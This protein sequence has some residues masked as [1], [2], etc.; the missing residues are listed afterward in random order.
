MY[1]NISL[2]KIL[3]F[4]L[5]PIYRFQIVQFVLDFIVKYSWNTIFMRKILTSNFKSGL[6]AIGEQNKYCIS[7]EWVTVDIDGSDI[8]HDFRS[9]K[10]LPFE[11][12]TIQLV[13]TSHMIE[14]LDE[15]VCSNVFKE[16]FR[17]LKVGGVF[18]VEAPDL[19][20]IILKYK[21]NDTE[22]F[23][24]LLSKK[25]REE[26]G[27]TL[28]QHDIFVGLISCYIENDTHIPVRIHKEEVDKNIAIMT[29]DEFA[30][31]CISFQTAEQ[32]LTGGH[33]QTVTSEKIIK[34]LKEAGFT[35]VCEVTNGISSDEFMQK[36]LAGIERSQHRS[37][38][39]LY[40]EA[41]K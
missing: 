6:L 19:K 28:H 17:L 22:F 33:I 24:K 27:K 26:F 37:T 12:N 35:E 30:N 21:S 7:P 38:Y 5:R 23:D 32:K 16:I 18:R 25:E 40:I 34:M 1:S 8:D 14:H 29:D 36:K 10:P 13:F 9:G 15:R 31:W 11:N 41:R 2:R 39:S 20:K 4:V 3:T